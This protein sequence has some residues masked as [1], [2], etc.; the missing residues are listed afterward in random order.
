MWRIHRH[1]FYSNSLPLATVNRRRNSKVSYLVHGPSILPQ[2][3]AIGRRILRISCRVGYS[4]LCGRVTLLCDLKSL[5]LANI[6][7]TTI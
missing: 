1:V 2:V 6:R 3:E 7:R 5:L 4:D